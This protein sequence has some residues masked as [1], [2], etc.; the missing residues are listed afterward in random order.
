MT[1]TPRRG[2]TKVTFHAEDVAA[3]QEAMLEFGPELAESYAR[4]GDGFRMIFRALAGAVDGHR[5]ELRLSAM[6][7]AYRRRRR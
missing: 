2:S 4:I 3:L 1:E 5:R 7:A 6:R